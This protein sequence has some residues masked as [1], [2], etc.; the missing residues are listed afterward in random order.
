MPL[1]RTEKQRFSLTAEKEMKTGG[2]DMEGKRDYYEILGVNRNADDSAIKKAYRK[3]AKKYH[4]D[5]NDGNNG[6]EEKFK[7]VTEAYDVLSD[8]GKRKLYDQFGH[9]AFDG[10]AGAYENGRS[11]GKTGF[12]GYGFSGMGGQR[13]YSHQQPEGNYQEFHFQGEDMDDIL[14]NIFEGSRRSGFKTNG[15]SGTNGY[16]RAGDSRGT[17]GYQRT[18]G[19]RNAGFAIDGSDLEAEITV[20]FDEAVFGCDKVINLAGTSENSKEEKT[21]QVHIPAGIDTGKTIRLKGR[22]MPGTGGGAPG[23]LLLKVKTGSRPGFERKD[24]DIYT[25][26]SIPFTT[27]VFGGEAVVQ[28]L[29]GN[30]VCKIAE[31]TQSGTKIRLRGKGVVSMKDP[32]CRGDQY[33]TVQIQVPKNLS[34]EAKRKLKEYEQACKGKRRSAA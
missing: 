12:G 15:F 10:G 22:G 7:E 24:M 27:A 8:P 25:T 17:D 21:F 34:E 11:A 13:A 5:M 30:V 3:L 9:A 6:A 26:V 28:T 29:Y 20:T 16:Q 33:V 18:G 4:P 19:F 31:G 23:D 14:R 32:N 1:F 2:K